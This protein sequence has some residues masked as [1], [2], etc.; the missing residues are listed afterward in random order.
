MHPYPHIYEVSACGGQSG[1]VAVE[2]AGLPKLDTAPPPEFGGPEG[3]WSPETL[4]CAAVADCFVLTFRSVG[5]AAKL[6]W[7]K[8]ECR[9]EGTLER[10][11]GVTQFTHFLTT[12]TLTVPGGADAARARSLLERAEH[13]CLVSNSLRAERV[14][15]TEVVTIARAESPSAEL[16]IP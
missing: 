15:R 8:L 9:V 14:L 12:A 4:L 6:E 16:F 2:S 11:D 5:R 3:V 10:R 1:S 7:V 13:A